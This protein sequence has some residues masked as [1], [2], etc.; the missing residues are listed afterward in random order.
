MFLYLFVCSTGLGQYLVWAGDAS[1]I[2]YHP[3]APGGSWRTYSEFI[4]R[5][6]ESRKAM[7]L[8][9]DHIRYMLNRTNEY[10]GEKYVDDPTIMSWELANE[11]RGLY[12]YQQFLKWVKTTSKLIKELDPN[13]LVTIG[14]EG[15][16]PDPS[17]NT[18]HQFFDC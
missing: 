14:L 11:P 13:H 8:Y 2:P 4:T 1:R 17:G 16:T 18:L 5:F 7:S 10:S 9:H 6:Y 3:P 12:R 15:D